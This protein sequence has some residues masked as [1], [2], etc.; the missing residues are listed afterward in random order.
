MYSGATAFAYEDSSTHN[1]QPRLTG[2]SSARLGGYS[3]THAY[4]AAGNPTTFKNATGLAYNADNQ[5]TSNTYDGNGNATTYAGVAGTYDPENR[6]TGFGS[7]LSASY[8]GDGLRASKTNAIGTTYFIYD[9]MQPVCELNTAGTVSAVNVFGANGLVSRSITTTGVTNSTFY[10]FDQQGSVAQ[11]LTSAGAVVSTDAY[12]AWGGRSSSGAADVFGYNAQWGY[13]TDVETGLIL[14]THRYYDPA[15]GRWL[16][17][18]PIGYAGGVNLYGYCRN[19]PLSFQDYTGRAGLDTVIIVV[20]II[21]VVIA[22][23]LTSGCGAQGGGGGEVSPEPPKLSPVSV[24]PGQY[25]PSDP[26]TACP[27]G[28]TSSTPSGE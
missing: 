8:N 10:T 17:R 7:A 1:A 26:A 11:R 6:L 16:T 19:E 15:R 13:Y 3:Q 4:D 27:K 25:P 2:E 21:V 22:V 20:V 18:D 28:S 24:P 23:I 5:R 14:C 9:G 12:D